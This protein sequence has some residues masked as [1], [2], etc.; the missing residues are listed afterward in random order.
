MTR[1]RFLHLSMFFVVLFALTGTGFS[2]EATKPTSRTLHELEGWQVFVDDRL[3][4]PGNRELGE[5]ALRLISNALFNI[6]LQVPENRVEELRQ[7]KI[8][9]DLSHGELTSAQYHPSAGWLTSHGY[10]AEL[11][12]SVHIPVAARF[13][14]KNTQHVQPWMVLHEL[15]HAYHDQFLEGGFK[16]PPIRRLWQSAID[17]GKYEQTLHINGNTT[18]HYALTD[19][20]E[21]FAEMTEAYF[22][23]NDFYPFVRGELQTDFPE[24]YELIR[25][26]WESPSR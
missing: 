19:P 25:G 23:R 7:V 26:I 2:D 21:F 8:F 9:L 1:F 17:S 24:C 16:N 5:R 10:D 6:A 4:E 3:F 13:A 15:A 20:M 18:K 14:S 12:K 22:G 11:E